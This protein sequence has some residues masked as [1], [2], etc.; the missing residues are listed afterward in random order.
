MGRSGAPPGMA[1]SLADARGSAETAVI[2]LAATVPARSRQCSRRAAIW[3][4][5]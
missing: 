5:V 3:S 1:V 2:G 4:P